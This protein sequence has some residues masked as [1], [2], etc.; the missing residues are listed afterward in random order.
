MWKWFRGDETVRFRCYEGHWGV[1]PKP[2]PARFLLPD[3][4]KKL[5]GR[6]KE[7]GTKGTGALR[8]S[9]IKRCAP[10]QDAMGTGWIIPLAADVSFKT[11]E[12]ASGVSYEWTFGS[13]MVENHTAE[14]IG[15]DDSPIHPRPPMKFLNWWQIIVPD[16]YSVLFLPPLNRPNPFFECMS[17]FVD[18]DKYTE[19]VNFPFTW[20]EGNYEGIIPSGTPLVQAIPIKR[21]SILT[22]QKFEVMTVPQYQELEK[23]RRERSAHESLYRDFLW[24]RKW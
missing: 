20:K 11:N 16:G 7:G 1:I 4:Y 22:S 10:F 17:G 21:D 13:P 24:E 3:W 2:Y 23:L 5:P 15:G 8:S 19:F 9:T 14:Q 12:D 6:I 18:C